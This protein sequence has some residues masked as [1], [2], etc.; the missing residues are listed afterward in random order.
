MKL[1]PKKTESVPS[2]ALRTTRSSNPSPFKV[3]RNDLRRELAGG[4]RADPDEAAVAPGVERDGVV[5][6]VDAGEHGCP[7]VFDKGDI[8]RGE[9][10][11]DR[12][13]GRNEPGCPGNPLPVEDVAGRVDHQHIGRCHRRSRSATR[14]VACGVV[15]RTDWVDVNVPSSLLSSDRHVGGVGIWL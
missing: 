2:P 7:A 11:V 9:A 3:G 13:G 6:G 1:V 5:V 15:A 8:A 4:E 10:G 14:G 12:D